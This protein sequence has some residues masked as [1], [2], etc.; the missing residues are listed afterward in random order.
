MLFAYVKL[1]NIIRKFYLSALLPQFCRCFLTVVE[2]SVEIYQAARKLPYLAMR[3]YGAFSVRG[4]G[5]PTDFKGIKYM[6]DK[7]ETAYS[8]PRVCVLGSKEAAEYSK[9]S[10]GFKK[11]FDY[12]SGRDVFSLPEGRC[13]LDSDR[14]FFT[15]SNSDLRP[16][17]DAPLEAHRKYADIQILLEGQERIGIKPA[18]SCLRVKTPYSAERDIE[19]FLDAP[20]VFLTLK[21][22]SFAV[23]MPSDAHAPLVGS[24]S[25]K[26][27]IV[28]VL[29]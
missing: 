28:K 11:F 27:C 23:F 5:L 3:Y 26:K 12:I 14:L 19:F 9:L 24:G 29:L 22:G 16:E 8:Y 4:Q 15:V 17:A 6:K 25:V 7:K 18:A 20:D 21:P 10:D 2:L 13:E 1:V